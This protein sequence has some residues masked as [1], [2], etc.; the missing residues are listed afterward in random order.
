MIRNLFAGALLFYLA[1]VGVLPDSADAV[2]TCGYGSVGAVVVLD[3]EK[4]NGHTFTDGVWG[5][6]AVGAS[7]SCGARGAA[8]S[9]SGNPQESQ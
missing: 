7:A 1:G 8:E 6:I 3:E 4:C 2:Y 5:C 9:R